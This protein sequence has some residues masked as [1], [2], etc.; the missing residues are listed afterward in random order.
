[1]DAEKTG[2][3][4]RMLRKE[5]GMTQKELA[6]RIMVSE[7]AVS[8]WERALGCPDVSLLH[9]L[10]QT[11]DVDVRSLLTGRIGRNRKD[12]SN[13][14]RIRFF[15]CP[16]CSNVAIMTNEAQ[17]SCCGR[18]LEPMKAAPCDEG[19]MLHM[20]PMDGEMYVTFS[21]PME[22]AHHLQ[23]VACAGYDRVLLVR[24]YAEQ[25]GEIRLPYMP[26]VTYYIGCSRDGLFVM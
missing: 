14:K 19:H 4:I 7:Q 9:L 6:D 11:L 23:F 5:K 8:K 22:K 26:R 16:I 21:H 24:L 18:V 3:L 25:G 12:G 15:V 2:T 1:M 13:M 10:A 17:A 20:E